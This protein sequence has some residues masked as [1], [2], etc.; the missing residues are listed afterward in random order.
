MKLEKE[1]KQLQF[2]EN[3]MNKVENK[4]CVAQYDKFSTKSSLCCF[5]L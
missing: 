4:N 5:E 3:K 2:T 1:E